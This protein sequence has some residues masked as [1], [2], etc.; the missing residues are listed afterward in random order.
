MSGQKGERKREGR[1]VNEPKRGMSEQS[2]AKL[3][4]HRSAK[5]ME[6]LRAGPHEG[7]PGI[8]HSMKSEEGACYATKLKGLK[9]RN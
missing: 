3:Q 9:P 8:D 6:P 5:N 4:R 2:Q 7:R 1:V